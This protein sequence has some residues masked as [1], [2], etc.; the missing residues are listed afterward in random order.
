[1]TPVNYHIKRS[2][3]HEKLQGN[4]SENELEEKAVLLT[5]GAALSTCGNERLG[6]PEITMSDG[7]HGVR[8]LIGHPTCPQECNIDRGDVCYP[9]AS[10]VGA[11]WN[12]SIHMKWVRQLQEIVLKRG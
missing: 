10:A 2:I 5:G 11:T 1:M 12:I 7:P 9:T 6:I 4:N 3:I 8:R